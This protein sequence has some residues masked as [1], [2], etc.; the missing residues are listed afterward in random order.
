MQTIIVN[1]PR[2]FPPTCQCL[3]CECRENLQKENK[4]LRESLA[5]EAEIKEDMEG[6]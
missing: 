1:K 4:Y 2:V 3:I 5:E 6:K